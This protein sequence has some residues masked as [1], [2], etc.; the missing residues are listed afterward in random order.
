MSMHNYFHFAKEI[1][2]DGKKLYTSWNI[3]PSDEYN[4]DHQREAFYLRNDYDIDEKIDSW[5]EPISPEQFTP[6]LVESLFGEESEDYDQWCSYSVIKLDNLSS[7][8]TDFIRTGYYLTDS[9]NR[10]KSDEYFDSED[11]LFE[12][13][14]P[15]VYA[16]KLSS[17]LQMSSEQLKVLVEEGQHLAS[18]YMHFTWVDYC[19]L[20]Y[21]LYMA[22]EMADFFYEKDLCLIHFLA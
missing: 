1:E 13:L 20:E 2:K 15:E 6:E 7:K 22:K 17:E 12:K 21:H 10:Y 14:E 4:E 8:Q 9:V 11:F 18:D 19:S 16:A 5:F 3:V